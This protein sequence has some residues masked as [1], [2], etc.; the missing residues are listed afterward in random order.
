VKRLIRR[1]RELA[2]R[3]LGARRPAAGRNQDVLGGVAPSADL[4]GVRI[5][6]D[7]VLLEHLGARGAEKTPIDAVQARDLRILPRD[8]L[9]PVDGAVADRPAES[10]RVREVFREV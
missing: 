5:D 2:A 3:D 6:D 7:R 10:R 4:D 1:D 9:R 8:E